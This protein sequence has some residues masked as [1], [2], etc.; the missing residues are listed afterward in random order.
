MRVSAP[1][2]QTLQQVLEE[3]VALGCRLAD[4]HDALLSLRIATAACRT[5]STPRR[6]TGRWCGIGGAWIEVERQRMDAVIVVERGPGALP[7]AARCHG[8]GRASCA[9]WRACA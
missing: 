1:A 7:Q 6:I 8:R 9:A 2:E 4:Q 5:T 3:L